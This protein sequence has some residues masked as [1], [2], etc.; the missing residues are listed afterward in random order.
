MEAFEAFFVG[1][2]ALAGILIGFFLR[3]MD[4][5]ATIIQLEQRNREVTEALN[6]SRSDADR[7]INDATARAAFESLAGEREKVIGQMTA[8][9]ERLRAEVQAK[10]D[11]EHAQATRVSELEA[12]LRNEREKTQG[13]M[14]LLENAKQTL[15]SQFEGLVAEVMAKK[16]SSL[17][18]E[19]QGELF[20]LL[21]PLRDQLNEFREKVEKAQFDSNS[22]VTKLESLIGTLGGLNQQLAQEARNLSSALRGSAKAQGDWGEII[23]RDLLEKAGLREGDQFSL[24]QS[25]RDASSQDGSDAKQTDVIVHLPGGR[26]LVIDSKVPLNAY[27]DSVNADLEEDRS[28]A[29]R[30]HLKVVRNH[31]ASVAQANYHGLPGIQTPDFVMMFVPIEPALLDALKGDSDIWTDAYEK[32]V[33]LA[34]PTTLLYVIRIV[35]ILWRQEDHNRVVKELTDHGATLY[36]R[37]AEFVNDMDGLGE[38]LHNASARYDDAK[39]KLSDGRDNLVSKFEEFK[40][41]SERPKLA[42]S[43][44]PIS[45]KWTAPATEDRRLEFDA[46]DHGERLNIV[47]VNAETNGYHHERAQELELEEAPYSAS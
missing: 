32:G 14:A 5:R 23:L 1:I 3:G 17:S 43:A 6:K 7:N 39:K 37:F 4:A 44:E 35:S 8:E 42:Q 19:N 2:A 22:G 45:F 10:A 27:L 12:D 36:S 30:E 25:F 31:I 40:Q 41:L 28:A 29:A 9:Q 18:S 38:S 26:H 16:S 20:S 15:A 46:E 34:G 24:Q 11:A 13:S 21:T 47:E 33:L